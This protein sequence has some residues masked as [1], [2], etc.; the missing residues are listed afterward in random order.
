MAK[1]PV[2]GAE[3]EEEK[4]IVNLYRC[5]MM[6]DEEAVVKSAYK[7]KTYYFCCLACQEAFEKEPERFLKA[8]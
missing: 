8:D 4:M 3:A 6:M 5:G 7:G 1:D 2:C